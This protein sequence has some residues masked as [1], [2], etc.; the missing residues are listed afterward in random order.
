VADRVYIM[1]TGRIVHEG[2][3]AE[4]AQQTELL[5]QRLGAQ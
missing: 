5:F 3:A 1:E 2:R 4:L